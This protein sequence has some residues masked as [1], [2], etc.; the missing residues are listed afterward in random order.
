MS[1]NKNDFML[2]SLD[3]LECM[4]FLS[5]AKSIISTSSL[6]ALGYDATFVCDPHLYDNFNNVDEEQLT[7]AKKFVYNKLNGWIPL[8][9][10]HIKS[11]VL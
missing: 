11:D 7:S 3:F 2:T 4:H 1:N 6:K 5:Q 10:Q 8:R 9:F